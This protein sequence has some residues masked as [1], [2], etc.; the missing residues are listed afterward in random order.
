MPTMMIRNVRVSFPHLF[1]PSKMGAYGAQLLLDPNEHGPLIEEI[2]GAVNSL[3]AGDLKG[4]RLP[5]EK[6]CL[7]LGG[8]GRPEYEGQWVLSSSQK[9]LVVDATGRGAITD[10]A[11]CP[12]YAGCRVHA[13]VDIWAQNNQHGKRIN[14]RLL[15]IQFAADDAP[16]EGNHVA[17]EVAM[18]GFDAVGGSFLD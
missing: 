11:A 9:P 13:K 7:R 18:D 2:K 4:A 5:P 15:A 8:N 3:I 10:P 14:A 1:Q 16:L 17:P 6:V 12:I